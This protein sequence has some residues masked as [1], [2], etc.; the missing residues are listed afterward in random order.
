LRLPRARPSQNAHSVIPAKAG[1]SSRFDR[2][3]IP[4]F[5]GMTTRGWIAVPNGLAKRE[6]PRVSRGLGTRMNG[7]GPGN[8]T[9]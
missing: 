1:I 8:P 4:A 9:D 7:S 2:Q 3:E 6:M 5:A